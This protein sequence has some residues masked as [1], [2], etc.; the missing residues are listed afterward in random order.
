MAQETTS[1]RPDGSVC[2]QSSKRFEHWRIEDFSRSYSVLN[3][4]LICLGQSL[5]Y[6]SLRE[7]PDFHFHNTCQFP[8]YHSPRLAPGWN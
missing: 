8:C 3:S 5:K 1:V 2:E 7:T 6:H 4:V